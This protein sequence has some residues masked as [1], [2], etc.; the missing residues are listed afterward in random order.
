MRPPASILVVQHDDRLPPGLLGEDHGHD[1]FLFDV[2]GY[3]REL[4]DAV[5]A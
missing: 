3:A 2:P 1:A 5:D 4:A